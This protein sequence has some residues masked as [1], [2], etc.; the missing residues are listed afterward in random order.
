MSELRKF[1]YFVNNEWK[2]PITA[3]YF[4]SENPATGLSCA[5]VPDCGPKDIDLAVEAAKNAFYSG[6]WGKMMQAERGRYLRK[7]G[8]II[9]K[10]AERIGKIETTDNGKLPRM[11]NRKKLKEYDSKTGAWTDEKRKE[12]KEMLRSNKI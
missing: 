2:E 4:E 1:K 11:G 8:E 9:S 7:I 3:A 12:E 10:H 5:L 6:H